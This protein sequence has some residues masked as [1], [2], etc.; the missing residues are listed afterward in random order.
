MIPFFHY[1]QQ[2]VAATLDDFSANSALSGYAGGEYGATPDTWRAATIEFLFLNM[3]AGFIRVLPVQT[4]YAQ[5]SPEDV[6][7]LLRNGDEARGRDATIVWNSV[8]FE[9][10]DTLR[11]LVRSRGLGSWESLQAGIDPLFEKDVKSA[12]ASIKLGSN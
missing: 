8:F 6:R 4:I 2:L 3:K 11:T 1:Q 9:A 7:E 5:S 10:T 12:Y